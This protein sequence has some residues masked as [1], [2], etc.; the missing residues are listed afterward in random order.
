MKTK[1]CVMCHTQMD[2]AYRIQIKR[3]KNGYLFVSIVQPYCKRVNFIVMEVL[4]KA[5][6][7]NLQSIVP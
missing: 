6:D 1:T 5:I 4:G 7:I 2:V 3:A